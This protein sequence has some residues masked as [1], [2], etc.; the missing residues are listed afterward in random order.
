M[1]WPAGDMEHAASLL[2][3]PYS[4]SGHVVHGRK[5]GRDLGRS[6]PD[7]DDGFRTLNLRFPHA[8]PAATGVFAVQTFGLATSR[9]PA[10]PAWACGR[11]SR[12]PGACC[13]R[14]TASSGPQALGARGGL[15]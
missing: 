5:L 4:I 3:R 8:R 6:A 15:R 2:G 11:R 10:W 14:C 9:C 1:R 12:T 7:R 13:S